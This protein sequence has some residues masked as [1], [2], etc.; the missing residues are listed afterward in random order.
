[1]V[2]E[3]VGEWRSVWRFALAG[4]IA[5]LLVAA[6]YQTTVAGPL[7]FAPVFVAQPQDRA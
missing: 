6:T 7:F 2:R 4:L 1:M 5:G 3:R